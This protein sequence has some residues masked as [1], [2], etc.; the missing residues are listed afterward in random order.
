M[1]C[2]WYISDLVTYLLLILDWILL[3]FYYVQGKN[4]LCLKFVLLKFTSIDCM[5]SVM[6]HSWSPIPYFYPMWV[7]VFLLLCFII[8]Y[9]LG[10]GGKRGL[11]LK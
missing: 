3:A 1:V 7:P 9:Y 4:K 10:A 5:T 6:L 8:V 2:R 11:Y